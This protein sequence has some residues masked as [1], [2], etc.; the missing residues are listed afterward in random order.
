M[1]RFGCCPADLSKEN[2]IPSI[3]LCHFTLNDI[4]SE[5]RRKRSYCRNS[6]F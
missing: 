4:S 6:F 2:L 5:W 1:S 3:F